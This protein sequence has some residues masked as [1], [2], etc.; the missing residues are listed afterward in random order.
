MLLLNVGRGRD[1][2]LN[3]RV[4]GTL[5]IFGVYFINYCCVWD[6]LKPLTGRDCN[7]WCPQSAVPSL[8]NLL[9]QTLSS[10]R[11]LLV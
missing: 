2:V 9:I 5:Q 8:K 11:E 7:S 3:P 1:V 4:R 10:C 6:D